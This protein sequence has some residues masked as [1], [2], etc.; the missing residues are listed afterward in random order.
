M[1]VAP[2]PDSTTQCPDKG[3][4]VLVIHFSQS[5]QLSALVDAVID[6]LRHCNG[7]DLVVE[8]L[9]PLAPYPFPWPF[10][11]FFDAFPE[12]VYLAPPPIAPLSAQIEGKFDLVILAYQVWFL[13]PSQPMTAF[14]Q[15]PQA[16][17][18]LYDTPVI[19]LIG[20]RNMWLMAQ[21]TMKSLLANLGARLVDNIV[22]TDSAH[23]ALTFF[24]TPVWVLTGNQGPFLGG[25]IPKAGIPPADI[26]AARRFGERIAR[27]L[28]S[29]A[30]SENSPMLTGLGAVTIN[31]RLIASERVALRSF[32]LWGGLLRAVGKPGTLPRRLVLVMYIIFL[33]TLIITVVPISAVLKRLAT[34]FVRARIARQRAYFAAPSGETRKPGIAP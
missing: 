31:D 10:M 27:V 8:T 1:I 7:V 30:R 15:S 17:Q 20:C 22:L 33:V 16:R 4:R 3:K 26:T 11:G 9:K 28:P 32:R 34:P 14:L 5:G 29:R 13:S 2:A 19:T 23:S 21:E 24:S 18:L 25:M 12:T 6:P